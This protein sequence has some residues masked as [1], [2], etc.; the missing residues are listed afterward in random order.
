MFIEKDGYYYLENFKK[1]GIL[2]VYSK[3]NS[4]NMSDYCN[5]LSE[6]SGTQLK[7]RRKLL[8]ILGINNKQEIMAY[9][10]H[11][12]NIKVIE[13]DCDKYYYEKEEN[14]DGFVTTRS[15]VVLF[16]FYADCL[17]IYVYDI[18]NKVIGVWHSGWLGSFK[19]IM[20]NG[21]NIMKNRYGT[22]TNDIILGLGIG[23]SQ[24]K[25]EVGKEFYEKFCEKF[26][27]DKEKMEIVY[28]SFYFDENTK[29]YYFD[30]TKFNHLMALLLGVLPENIEVASEDTY[31]EK[32]FSHRRERDKSGRAAGI[33]SFFE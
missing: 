21:F 1:Y 30:N 18:K 13:E 2:A 26:Q 20:S 33:I 4:G 23:I 32:F 29:K 31:E 22:E 10:T 16:T 7:N 11:S 14:I 6:P 27:S 8:R 17:P 28:K 25:Y 24:K 12:S 9:Q 5:N 19:E 15:D 3:K